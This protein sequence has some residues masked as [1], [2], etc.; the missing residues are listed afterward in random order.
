MRNHPGLAAAIG[1]LSRGS[2]AIGNFD[3]VHLGHQALFAAARA[4]AA[5]RRGPVAAL[6][7]APHPARVLQPALAPPLLC[8]PERKRE[9]LAAQGVTDLVEQRFDHAFAAT[10]PDQFVD[11][12][13]ATGVGEVVVGADFTY[14]RSRT[15]R[16]DSLR[17]ALEE[18]GVH[19][20]LIP[21]VEVNG[22][23]VSSTKIRELVLEGKVDHAARLLGRP[24][25]ATGEVVKGDGRGRTLGWPTANVGTA[26]E[27]L[28]A[29][30]V[31]AVRFAIQDPAGAFGPAHPGA[32]N[33]GLNPTFR[34]PEATRAQASLEVFVLEF[35][36][37]L[38]G[39][40][41]RVEFVQRL[42]SEQRFAGIEALKAQIALDV[43]GVRRV[44]AGGAAGG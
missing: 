15:G 21:P 41:V 39:R 30:G 4:G 1:Q 42:R 43:E 5:L 3:G 12:L 44:F 26:A 24:F 10:D 28:P 29:L 37:D 18:R 19:L 13:C 32:A 7:F 16:A 38:Y 22:V 36:G 17:R 6:T 27:I 14:G 9:L 35:S 40:T 31:Y 34:H 33:L 8:P 20:R 11:L 25:A 23:V 2:I